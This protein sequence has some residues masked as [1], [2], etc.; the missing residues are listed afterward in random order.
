MD[1]P[2]IGAAV[3]EADTTGRSRQLTASS[4]KETRV[5]RDPITDAQRRAFEKTYA[6]LANQ[7]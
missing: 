3:Q 7:E 1:L 6:A 4:P 2:D 5:S